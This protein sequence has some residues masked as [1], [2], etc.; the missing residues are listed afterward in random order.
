MNWVGQWFNSR[1]NTETI[2]ADTR[3]GLRLLRRSY[4]FAAIAVLTRAL[5]IGASTAVLS[6]ID[7][8]LL[9]PLPSKKIARLYT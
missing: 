1:R 6:I 4:G 8:F 9:R 5:G 7:A 3:F 2:F